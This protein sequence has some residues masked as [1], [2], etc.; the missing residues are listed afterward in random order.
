MLQGPIYSFPNDMMFMDRYP[1]SGTIRASSSSMTGK[2]FL[3]MRGIR[4]NHS[5]LNYLLFFAIR[6][7]CKY[8]YEYE[9]SL[10]NGL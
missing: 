2:C 1:A 3:I 5:S 7:E 10:S 9:P 6:Y 8:E 4:L